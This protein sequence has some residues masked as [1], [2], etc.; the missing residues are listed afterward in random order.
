[1]LLQKLSAG[2]LQ[3]TLYIA[4]V[5]ALLITAFILLVYAHKRFSIT[6]DFIIE[7][8]QNVD[9]GILYALQNTITLND[10]TSINLSDQDYKSLNAYRN[11]WGAFE[12]VTAVASI[13]KTRFVKTALIGGI[14]PDTEPI[15]LY[16]KDNNK[17]LVVVGNTKIEG[18]A[19]LPRQG[20][21]P[22][23]IAG[24][25]YYGSQLIYG[26]TT[27]VSNFPQL[28][29]QTKAQLHQL[30][31][32]LSTVSQNQFLNIAL[33]RAFV[34]SFLDPMQIVF[35]NTQ[36][37]L[38]EIEL[39]GHIV[40]KSLTKITVD[41]STKLKDVLLIAPEIEIKNEVKGNFQAIA[42]KQLIVGNNVELSYPSALIL[43]ETLTPQLQ[44]N[45]AHQHIQN[46]QITIAEQS[47]IKGVVVYLGQP[48]PNN[49]K[50]QLKLNEQAKVIGEVYCNQNLELLGQVTG[51]VYTNNFI[52]KQLGSIYQNH[53]YNGTILASDLSQEYVGLTFQNSKKGIVKWLY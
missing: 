47:V 20:I 25:S 31:H 50:V 18:K 14:Q 46:H 30:K 22:G 10:T 38:S 15:A 7:T 53:I 21:K 9:K 33:G 51:T 1:M 42:S 35:S 12:K 26:T 40:V 34:N 48:K 39:T 28:F 4:I 19:Y 37:D 17:P 49:H 23:T 16:I 3:F 43:N 11:Y 29:N 45:L 52:A 8:T 6:T 27:T 32:Q 44:N 2:A 24:R 36:I 13:K 41:N 5:I